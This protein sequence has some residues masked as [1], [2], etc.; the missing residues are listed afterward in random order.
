MRRILVILMES[1]ATDPIHPMYGSRQLHIMNRSNDFRPV[2]NP[3][4]AAYYERQIASL[5]RVQV[6][7][8]TSVWANFDFEQQNIYLFRD[9]CVVTR[10]KNLSDAVAENHLPIAAIYVPTCKPTALPVNIYANIAKK[11]SLWN[12]TS[13]NTTSLA[14]STASV[15]TV[16]RRILWKVDRILWTFRLLSG[17]QQVSTSSHLFDYFWPPYVLEHKIAHESGFLVKP[18]RLYKG[19]TWKISYW[20]IAILVLYPFLKFPV[21]WSFLNIP[22]VACL[23]E[24][25]WSSR[26]CLDKYRELCVS[27]THFSVDLAFDRLW[28]HTTF[29]AQ[30]YFMDLNLGVVPCLAGASPLFNTLESYF[31]C[32]P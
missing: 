23:I 29:P 21:Y 8:E 13:T 14:A 26:G 24:W 16:L 10:V 25:Y 4:F 20:P 28:A 15:T 1:V 9:I 30:R 27:E 6:K 18:H 19:K 12:P 7:E 17:I 5:R 22:F 3:K 31:S 2:S 11:P 32:V